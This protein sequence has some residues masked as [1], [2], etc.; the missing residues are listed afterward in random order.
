MIESTLRKRDDTSTTELPT[1][2]PARA[3]PLASENVTNFIHF[4]KSVHRERCIHV[5]CRSKSRRCS[6]ASPEAYSVH[7]ESSPDRRNV[8]ADDRQTLSRDPQASLKP[9]KNQT[10][11]DAA[12]IRKAQP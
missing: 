2:K 5:V 7:Y 9:A 8:H 12:H 3:I 1:S 6:P 11:T 10:L 4:S